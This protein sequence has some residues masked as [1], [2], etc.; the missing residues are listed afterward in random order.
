MR[1]T[2]LGVVAGWRLL[3]LLVLAA[4]TGL[5]P[6]VRAA[7]PDKA[8]AGASQPAPQALPG[9]TVEG[10]PDPLGRSDRHLHQLQESLPALGG[11]ASHKKHFKDRVG[12]YLA[13]HKDP[14]KATGQQRRM[15]ERAQQPPGVPN[16]PAA[17]P[18]GG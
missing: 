3:A 17:A 12:D 4:A 11:N 6:A 15:M 1:T 16:V 2:V 5:S 10:K 9:V 13:K 8:A 18:A 7:D 14:E